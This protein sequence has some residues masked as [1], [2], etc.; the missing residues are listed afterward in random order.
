MCQISKDYIKDLTIRS[1]RS[2]IDLN[3]LLSMLP[4]L[5]KFYL[6]YG[7]LNAGMSFEMDMFGMKEED[8][9]SLSIALSNLNKLKV[10]SLKENKIDD[11]LLRGL[12]VGLIENTSITELGKI[13]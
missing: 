13:N 4:N 6:K 2:H 7:V 12:L 5:Q 3:N 9:K 10:L 8:V 11:N 1:L